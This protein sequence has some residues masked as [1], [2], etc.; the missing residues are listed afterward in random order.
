MRFVAVAVA[1]ASAS[2]A[3]A[4]TIKPDPAAVAAAKVP[5]P[6]SDWDALLKEY[7]DGKGRVDYNAIDRAA[8]DKVFAAV[9]A[10]SPKKT[11]DK[12]PSQDAQKAFYLNAY[13]V[14]AWK[15]VLSRLPKLKNVNDSKLSFF[16]ITKFVVGG[17]DMNLY[18]L[19]NKIVRPQFKD[20]RMHFALNC[21]SGG[22]PQ[23]PAEAFTP[24]KVDEQLSREARKFCNEKRNV[25][26]DAA[27]KKLKLSHIFDWYKDDFGKEPAK[28]IAWINHYRSEGAQLPADGKIEYVDYD[29]TLNDQHL[30]NR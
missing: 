24:A 2:V 25:D 12:Y 7:V 21:A 4:A 20:A 9:A 27:T 11:P 6:Y 5:F 8:F 13:N 30:L 18:D 10:S 3:C 15:D 26:F 23:L 17:D 14:L 1:L 29:W 28:V 16:Y 22:C 19:E